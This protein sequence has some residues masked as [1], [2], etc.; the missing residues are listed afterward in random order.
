MTFREVVLKKLYEFS[1]KI[2]Y[3]FY[4]MGYNFISNPINKYYNEDYTEIKYTANTYYDREYDVLIVYQMNKNDFNI[5]GRLGLCW[6]ELVDISGVV[7]RDLE[8]MKSVFDKVEENLLRLGIPFD[9]SYKFSQKW[10]Y[11]KN[12]LNRL[13]YDLDNLERELEEVL[14]NDN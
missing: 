1:D 14:D 3:E 6:L 5:N 12:K 11:K 7:K 4:M 13:K 9:N 10:K 2:H 8:V